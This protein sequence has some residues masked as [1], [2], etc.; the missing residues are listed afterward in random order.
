MPATTRKTAIRA[1]SRK[2]GVIERNPVTGKVMGDEERQDIHKLLDTIGARACREYAPFRA[3]GRAM[4]DGVKKA[5]RAH[6]KEV[7]EAL[8]LAFDSGAQIAARAVAAKWSKISR[9]SALAY[10]FTG[11]DQDVSPASVTLRTPR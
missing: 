10:A 6:G 2:R 11:Q 1:A 3:V 7:A 4:D 5:R 8:V 9:A